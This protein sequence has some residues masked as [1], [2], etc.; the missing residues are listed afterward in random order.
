MAAWQYPLNDL[1]KFAEEYGGDLKAVMGD[2]IDSA[3]Y[4]LGPNVEGFENQFS[5]YLD[6]DYCV[7]VANGTDAI[8]IALRAVGVTK[9]D[10][11]ATVANA[12]MYASTA[13][14]AIGASIKYLDVS[15]VS[16]CATLQ[17]V[18]KSIAQGVKAVIVTHLYG[19]V[20]PEIAEI[21]EACRDASIFLVEDCAQ[22][23]GAKVGDRYAGTFGDVASFSFYPTKN[24]GGLGDGGCV[25][26][27]DFRIAE[28]CKSLRQYGWQIKYDVGRFGGR[29]SRLDELQAAFLRVLLRS[30]DQRNEKRKKIAGIYSDEISHPLVTT[31]MCDGDNYVAHLYVITAERRDLLRSYLDGKG[32]QTE[33]HYPIPDHQQE[34]YQHTNVSPL[35]ITTEKLKDQIL[36]LP[37][38]PEMNPDAAVHIAKMVN[39]WEP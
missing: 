3:W 28:T 29:N 21:A 35:L 22:S 30:L 15:P 2:V 19:R 9:H 11:V 16:H 17:Q 8:E 36:T 6:T 37:C 34:V 31:P 23:H 12:G 4:V 27:N 5:D 13:I 1:S 25:V 18:K 32:I 26:T 33:I 14:G 20:V 39:A 7:G 38:F 10:S 24:L